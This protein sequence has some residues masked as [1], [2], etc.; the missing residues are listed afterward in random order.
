[1]TE[2][3]PA[4]KTCFVV[5]PIGAEGSS[6]RNHADWL[7]HEI[8]E[9][10]LDQH[11]AGKFDVT[12][13]DKIDQPGMIDA[14]IIAHLLDDDVVI[15]DMSELNPNAFYEMGIRHMKELP[16]THMFKKGEVIP[17]D[18]KLYRAIQFDYSN[19]IS[20]KEARGDLRRSIEA[21]LDPTFKPDN[22]VIRA[23]GVQKLNEDATPAMLLVTQQL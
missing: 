10:V 20:L 7:Y 11:F 1:M 9:H 14:Q 13:S 15:A 8:I 21:V 3:S 4:K 19:P 18:V 5:C 23:R 22:P 2:K 16:I 6:T 12:R 17:F